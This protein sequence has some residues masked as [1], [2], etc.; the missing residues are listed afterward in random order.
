MFT[1]LFIEE[2]RTQAR[3]NAGVVGIVAVI[4]AGFILL[5]LLE[6]PVVSS[7]L[8][9]GAFVALVAMPGVVSVQVGIEYWA[10]MYGAR[11]YLTMSLPVKGR[12]ILAAKTLYAVIAVL[13]SAAV[14][15]LLAIGWFAAYAHLV[16]A[17]LGQLLEPVRQM[18]STV[19][20]GMV[21][22]YGLTVVEGVVVTIIEVAA[23]MSIGGQGRWNRLGFGAPAVGLVIL[24]AVNQV[25]GLVATVLLPLSL[26]LASGRIVGRMMLPQFIEAARTGQDPHLVGIGS[27]VAAPVLAAVLVWWAVRAIE[28]HTCLR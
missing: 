13:V 7:M 12:V 4:A 11:G 5:S 16:G 27:V 6:L 24:Y 28:R 8:L 1:T 21:V 26:D 18:I 10:S 2:V 15:T 9:A 3:R 19:G 17:T 23:V 22:F 14:A 25:V 20:T